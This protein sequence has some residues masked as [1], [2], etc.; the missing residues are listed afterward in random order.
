M[1]MLGFIVGVIATIIT[2][3]LIVNCII[4]I[5]EEEEKGGDRK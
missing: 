4:A 5:A 1:F 3:I 2:M